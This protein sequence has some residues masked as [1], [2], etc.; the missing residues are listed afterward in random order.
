[1]KNPIRAPDQDRDRRETRPGWEHQEDI[2][3]R[4]LR[5]VRTGLGSSKQALRAN[6]RA[7][8]SPRSRPGS[9]RKKR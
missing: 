9:A 7:R 8:R 4:T 6:R 5:P 1:M 2:C 3:K